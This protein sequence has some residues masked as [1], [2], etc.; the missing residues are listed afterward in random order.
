MAG[1]LSNELKAMLVLEDI[2]EQGVS[3]WHGNCFTIQHF[4]YECRRERDGDG[5][6]YGA[7]LPSTL[8]FTVKV[9]AGD[10][11]K[12]FFKRMGSDETFPYSFLFNATFS[13]NGRLS[14]C[15]DAMV[16]TG[17]LTD[18]EESYGAVSLSDGSQ[19]QMLIHVKLLLSNLAYLGREKT[20]NLTLTN[21]GQI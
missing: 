19:E 15:E 16:A 12:H 3:V 18:V 8:E 14:D 9:S 6:P 5:F 11:G 2:S 20:L 4:S 7:T 1:V 17:Y 13:A 21:D 10:S